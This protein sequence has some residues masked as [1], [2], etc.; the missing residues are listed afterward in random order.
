MATMVDFK[1][2]SGSLVTI[3]ISKSIPISIETRK[4]DNFNSVILS[5][6]THNNGGYILHNDETRDKVIVRINKAL[7]LSFR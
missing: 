1:L 5:H 6:P 7:S 2:K 4:I 3:L